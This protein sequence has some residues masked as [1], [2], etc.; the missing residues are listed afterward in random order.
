[1]IGNFVGKFEKKWQVRAFG[2]LL[3]C[4]SSIAIWGTLSL[5]HAEKIT[6]DIAVFSALNKVTARISQLEIKLNDTVTFGALKITP[7]SCLSRPV[8][9]KPWTSAFIEVDEVKLSGDT[10]RIFSGWMFAQSPG[11]HA[12]EHPVF[13]VWLINCKTSTGEAAVDN[14]KKSPRRRKA[15]DNLWE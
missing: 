4:L 9:E 7:R 6:N 11:L 15:L 10:Q 5:A 12:V 3:S 13:D 8:T 2:V 1:M 14:R